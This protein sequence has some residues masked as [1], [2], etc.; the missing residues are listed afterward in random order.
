MA[1]RTHEF[2]QAPGDSEGQGGLTCCSPGGRNESGTTERLNDS[3]KLHRT[4]D[5]HSLVCILLKCGLDTC[6]STRTVFYT[7][8][9]L[10]K[11]QI[12]SLLGLL[13]KIKCSIC[14]YQFN[15]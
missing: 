4:S 11:T 2:E 3:G 14:S 13:A 8:F 10:L 1:S 9:R 12:G 5:P 7:S 15:I 6:T